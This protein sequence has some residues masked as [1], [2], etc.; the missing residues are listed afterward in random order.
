MDEILA[1]LKYGPNSFE[2][3]EKGS[4][5]LCAVTGKKIDMGKFKTPTLRNISQTSPYMHDGRFK[6]LREV[7]D[8]YVQGGIENP[9]L[10]PDMGKLDLTEKEKLNLESFLRTLDGKII[11]I[12]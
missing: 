6:T 11:K 10:D 4:Y 9:N 2:V 7:I 5:V 8:F 1:K 3:L 12:K